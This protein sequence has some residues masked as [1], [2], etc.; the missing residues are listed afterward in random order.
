MNGVDFPTRRLSKTAARQELKLEHGA[1][2]LLHVGSFQEKKNHAGV[3]EIFRRV[4][5]WRP[6][7][8]LLLVGDGVLRPQIED[9][10]RRTGLQAGVRFEGVQSNVWKYYSAADAFVFASTVEGFA[11]VLVE[12]QYARL[13]LVASD[14]PPHHESVAPMQHEFLYRLPCYD[15]AAELVR[16]QVEAAEAGAH[17]WV[18]DSAEYVQSRFSSDRFAADLKH[19]YVDLAGQR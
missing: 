15:R 10:V 5:A 11:N 14:I 16:T 6:N 1:L 4:L 19:L 18:D 12:C 13:P 2:V 7:S 8:V 17:P 9:T 3:L